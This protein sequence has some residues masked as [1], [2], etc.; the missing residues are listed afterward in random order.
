MPTNIRQYAVLPATPDLSALYNSGDMQSV[1]QFLRTQVPGV[2]GKFEVVGLPTRDWSLDVEVFPQPPPSPSQLVIAL[3]FEDMPTLD[4]FRDGMERNLKG[5]FGADLAG[6]ATEY[7][8]PGSVDQRLFGNRELARDLINADALTEQGL[9]GNGVNVVVVDRGLDSRFIPNFRGGWRYTDPVTH[10][11]RRPG[12]TRGAD[13]AHGTMMVRNIRD[14]APDAGIWDF[15]IIP[16]RISDDA[17]FTHVAQ[18][19]FN[20]ML[21]DI[22]FLSQFPRWS[23]PWILVNAWAIFDR[24]TDIPAGDYTNRLTHPFNQA[25][26]RAANDGHDVVFCAGNCGQFCPDP[27]CGPR[28]RGPGQSILGANSHPRAI[29]V[30]AARTDARW[31]GY[32]SQGPGQ[33]NLAVQKPDICAPSD[34]SET[35]D[36]Y[37]GN[38]GTSAASGVTAGVIAAL[39]SRWSRGQTLSPDMLRIVLSLTA[40]K[41]EGPGWNGRLGN[42]IL[43]VQAVLAALETVPV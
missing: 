31:L 41:T 21:D 7:W 2:T 42:G 36:A 33:P 1:A 10:A 13:A 25:V 43:D 12:M 19:A 3:M 30:G 20:A 22:Q 4:Q 15:P 16:P 34:F 18:V 14:A 8:C 17:V 6:G 40:R 35:H 32:A 26:T 5:S 24:S 23:G 9:L 27:R 11:V 29:S 37:T 38:T 39:R 28:D